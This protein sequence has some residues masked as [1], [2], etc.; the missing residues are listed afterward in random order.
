[1]ESSRLLTHAQRLQAIAQAGMAYPTSAYYGERFEEI[2]GQQSH[3]SILART[4]NWLD[5]GN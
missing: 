1:M 5:A 3:M 4:S 2:T